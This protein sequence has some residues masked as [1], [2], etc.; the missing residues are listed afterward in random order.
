MRHA[1]TGGDNAIPARRPFMPKAGSSQAQALRVPPMQ[2][3]SHAV[4]SHS[5]H[6]LSPWFNWLDDRLRLALNVM[7]RAVGVESMNDAYRG[8]Y[9]TPDEVDRLLAQPSGS[10]L[11]GGLDAGGFPDAALPAEFSRVAAAVGLTPFDVAAILIAAAPELDLRYERLYAFLQ[12]DVSRKRPSVDLVLNLLCRDTEEKLSMRKRFI[13][14]APLLRYGLLQLLP[15]SPHAAPSLAVQ[16]LKPDAQILAA[17]LGESGMDARLGACAQ[18]LPADAADAV[19]VFADDSGWGPKFDVLSRI[20]REA[21]PGAEPLRCHLHGADALALQTAAA[22]L[23]S[24]IRSPMLR[25]DLALLKDMAKAAALGERTFAHTL[26]AAFRCA[27]MH[28]AMICFDGIDVLYAPDAV[29]DLRT[30]LDHLEHPI[31]VCVLTGSEARNFSIPG[32]RVFNVALHAL[33]RRDR[34]QV[35]QQQL[36]RHGLSADAAPILASRFQLSMGQTRDAVRTAADQLRL[37]GAAGVGSSEF[38]H[39]LFAAAR[40]QTRHVFAGLAQRIEPRRNWDDLILPDDALAQLHEISS[41]FLHQDQVLNGWGFA[42]KIGYGT[43]TTVLF[44]GPSGT[45]KTMAAEVLAQAL[46]LD[47]YRIDLAAVVSK[48]I[49]ETEK[50]LDRL[51]NAADQANAVLFFDEADALFGKRTE[52]KDSH[53]RYANLEI[54]YLLQKME[55]Y[56]GIAILASNLRQN[57]DEAFIRRLAFIVHFPFPDETQRRKIWSS[58]WPGDVRLADDVDQDELARDLKFSGGNIKNVALAAAFLAAADHADDTGGII[59]REHI[60]GAAEREFQKLGRPNSMAKAAN[61]GKD[62]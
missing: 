20:G 48:Y 59:K 19:D 61:T 22:A 16:V 9:V 51:F 4:R 7:R 15:D 30:L 37:T 10:P 40:L 26:G 18:L 36:S 25:L 60:H 44:A 3:M 32:S 54:S 33:T 27:W 35:W 1:V 56:Q 13:S 57:L 23:A 41:R 50:N 17:L 5:D 28:E 47:L 6:P 62:A 52:V 58:V 49:G 31:A 8:L 55:Q 14:P 45:G 11:F 43:G 34:Q 29:V 39:M 24:N 46:G 53:D 38:E 2:R 21:L 12:D 42:N